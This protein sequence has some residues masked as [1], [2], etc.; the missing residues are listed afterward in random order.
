MQQPVLE[1]ASLAV[2][3]V[4]GVEQEVGVGLQA[5]QPDR[6][7]HAHHLIAQQPRQACT[8]TTN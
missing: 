6:L 4:A 3:L 2:E 1:E 8:A 7:R 5:L